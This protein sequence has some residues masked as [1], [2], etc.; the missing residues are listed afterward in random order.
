MFAGK[1]ALGLIRDGQ[2]MP[3][4]DIDICHGRHPDKLTDVSLKSIGAVSLPAF[5]K[6]RYLYMPDNRYCKVKDLR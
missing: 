3:H 6:T 5:A 1:Y 2:I 4:V